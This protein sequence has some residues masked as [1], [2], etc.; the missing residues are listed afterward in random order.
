MPPS[1][2]AGARPSARA[3]RGLPG[4]GSRQLR[5]DRLHAAGRRLRAD[6]LRP[7]GADRGADRRGARAPSPSRLAELP[8]RA[9][10]APP[11]KSNAHILG[12]A[13]AAG[14]SDAFPAGRRR[15]RAD[16]AGGHAAAARQAARRAAGTSGPTPSSPARLGAGTLVRT[17]STFGVRQL[18]KLIP[19]YGQTAGAAAA[20]AASFAATYAM[21]KAASYF[22]ARRRQGAAGGGGRLR[23]SQALREAFGL[24]KERDIGAERGGSQAMSEPR[25]RRMRHPAL[26]LLAVA[27]LLPAASLHAAR[28]L[29][30]WQHGYIIYWA[31]GTCIVVIAVY[32]LEQAPDRAAAAPAPARRG[33]RRARRRQLDPAPGE[34]WDDVMRSPRKSMRAERMTSRDA[35]LGLGLETIEV[36]ARRLHPERRDPLLQ[37]TVPEALAVIERASA[38]LRGF[39]VGRF[40]ARRP[41]Y[42]CAAHVALPLARRAAA[43]PRRATTCGASC[44]CSIP[45]AAAT[46]ELRE[47]FTRQIYDAGREHLA[48][49][50]ARRLRQGGRARG[51]RSLR[52]QPARHGRT[53]LR[54]ARH[55]GLARGT[56]PRSR[57]ARPSRSAFW[58]P[59]RPGPASR[60]WSTRSP[61]PWRPPSMCVPRPRAS[62][63]TGSAEG[64]PAALIIDSPGLAGAGGA[65]S[66]DRG[67]RRLRHGA[68]G[69]L[70]RAGGPRNRSR[71]R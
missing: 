15:R 1:L 43:W 18:V 33:R 48:R 65:R 24:A 36:V 52:R 20:A 58:W 54:D 53:Q 10:T 31:I 14:A 47:R 3:V 30:L 21:G 34:A 12:F 44:A 19:V 66:A 22:L 41:H 63:P 42:G 35:A 2:A 5:A 70:G 13:L 46:Q 59:A 57:H 17:A 7:R 64:L 25:T 9:P 6:R 49:R 38:N 8:A 11:R 60:A 61:T 45:V 51:H 27:L 55:G 39:V 56:W 62:P 68:V 37:F 50:L 28:Q 69:G 23:L 4:R 40:P 26:V 32:Y 29:W 16:G 67:R 71:G